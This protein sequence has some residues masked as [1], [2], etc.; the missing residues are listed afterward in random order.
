MG[1]IYTQLSM[2]ERRRIE[3]WWRAKVPVAEMA[4][5]LKHYKSTIFRDIKRNF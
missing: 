1:A 4:R 3:D 5:A 2:Q